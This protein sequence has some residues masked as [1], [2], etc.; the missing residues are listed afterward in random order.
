M[1]MMP[2]P[3]PDET[4]ASVM[5]ASEQIRIG[6]WGMPRSGK[7]VYL[8]MLYLGLEPLDAWSIRP[9]TPESERLLLAAR[10]TIKER[11]LFPDHTDSPTTY[12]YEVTRRIAAPATNGGGAVSTVRLLLEFVDVPGEL[13]R[14]FYEY[15]M[16]GADGSGGEPAIT[17]PKRTTAPQPAGM[18]LQD[19]FAMLCEMDGLLLFI[20]PAWHDLTRQ[21][22]SYQQ[23]LLNLITQIARHRT[24]PHPP[25]LALCMVKADAKD[26]YWRERNLNHRCYRDSPVQTECR[27]ACPLYDF[28]GRDMRTSDVQRADNGGDA[29]AAIRSDYMERDLLN[30]LGADR[31]GTMKCFVLSSIGRATDSKRNVAHGNPWE[32]PPAPIPPWTEI[33]GALRAGFSPIDLHISPQRDRPVNDFYPTGIVDVNALKPE[34]LL[35]P[36]QWIIEQH[37]GTDAR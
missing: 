18:T 30:A 32:R 10:E 9:T 36:L 25:L 33:D 34:N 7:T 24:A 14:E 35:L 19:R 5:P 26:H 3:T 13:D 37:T 8:T 2:P 1:V 21:E 11:R 12:S 4:P 17:V 20:D 23:L 22:R 29:P 28:L 15:W 6:I 16:Q 31:R 27:T